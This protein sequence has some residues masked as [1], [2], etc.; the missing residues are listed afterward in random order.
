MLTDFDLAELVKI[1]AEGGAPTK[2]LQKHDRNF[3]MAV[4]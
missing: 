2:W 1:K 3:R 4:Q